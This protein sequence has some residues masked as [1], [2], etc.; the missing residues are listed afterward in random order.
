VGRP[1]PR[2]K[3]TKGQREQ[4]LDLYLREAEGL[5]KYA[6]SISWVRAVAEPQDLV[7][8]TFCEAVR[9]W[10]TVGRLGRDERRKWLRRVLKNKATD[11]WRKQKVIDL[12]TEFPH[13][14][15]E[16][17]DPCE[18]AEYAI[19]LASVW[20][21]IERMPQRRREVV[22]LAWGKWWTDERIAEHLEMAPSTVRGHIL[23]ARR[24]LR[25]TI[26]HLVSFI[27]DETGEEP[28]S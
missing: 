19:A 6:C 5:H 26:G 17:D 21:E 14:H 1:E 8:T 3:L 18:R 12:T 10:R 13:Q 28:T 4:V 16:S 22:F 2:P 11:V 24:Q 9:A 15:S 20:K 27:D 25:A 7:H 23:Q